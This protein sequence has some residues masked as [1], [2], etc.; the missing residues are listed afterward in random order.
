MHLDILELQ[1]TGVDSTGLYYSE[2]NIS[3]SPGLALALP[4]TC[5]GNDIERLFQSFLLTI[6]F[7]RISLSDLDLS[8]SSATD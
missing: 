6:S 2:G 3:P 1:G 5:N 4:P 8:P 7:I